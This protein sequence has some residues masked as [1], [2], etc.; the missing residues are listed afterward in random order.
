MTDVCA[1]GELGLR[2]ASEIQYDYVWN[3]VAGINAVGGNGPRLYF[4]DQSC[5]LQADQ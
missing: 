1:E 5:L 4:A 3:T 2:I